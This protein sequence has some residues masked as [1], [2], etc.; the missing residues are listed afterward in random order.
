MMRRIALGTCVLLAISQT[1]ALAQ[2]ATVQSLM[3]DGYAVVGVIPSPAGPGVFLTKG[4]V[5]MVC[6]VAEKPGT[7]IVATQYC[8]PV[9]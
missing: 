7:A 6:F 2:D 3:T 4:Q 9:R 5:L 8:K 1:G